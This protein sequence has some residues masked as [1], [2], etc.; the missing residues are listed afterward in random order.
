[1]NIAIKGFGRIGRN[2]LRAYLDR[3]ISDFKVDA[4]NDLADTTFNAHLLKY[5]SN[6]GT[7][8]EDVRCTPNQITVGEHKI[9]CFSERD[10]KNL[11]WEE[12]KIDIVFECTGFFADKEAAKSHIDAGASRVIVSAPCKNADQTIVYGVNQDNLKF[13]DNIISN[14]S[15]TT[16]CLA[17]L[18]K[19]IHGKFK[20][21]EGLVNTIHS[22]TN[23]QNLLDV[24]HTD[25]YRA[26]AAT[27]SMIPTKT[28]AASA[29]GLVIPE[30]AGKLNGLATRIPLPNVSLLDFTFSTEIGFTIN[31]LNEEIEKAANNELKGILDINSLPLVSSDFKGNMHSSIYDSSH[32]QVIGNTTK[33]LAW[34]DNEWGFANRMI[35]LTN[36]IKINLLTKDIAA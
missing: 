8:Q 19:V 22:Y 17:P 4:I 11:P 23:D 13:E 26:R 29:V 12:L 10:P 21:K 35:D 18:A 20:I 24:Q 5:D 36:Y 15:C 2:I 7:L 27:Q 34:Y 14:V 31:E 9:K 32:T 28:G 6:Q 16:N 33:V 3:K 1:M 25:L 30:L